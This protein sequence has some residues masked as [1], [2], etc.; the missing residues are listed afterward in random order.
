MVVDCKFGPF[1]IAIVYRTFGP[2]I[3]MIVDRY[4]GPYKI[5]VMDQFFSFFFAFK[6]M[7]YIHGGGFHFNIYFFT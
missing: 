5:T 3:T 4:F 1:K 6:C 7:T 2:S